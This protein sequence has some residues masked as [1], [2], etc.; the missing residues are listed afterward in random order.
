MNEAI[1]SRRRLAPVNQALTY[2]GCGRT[3]AY[4]LIGDGEIVAVKM[5]SRTMIDLDSV[6]AYH[7]ALPRVTSKGS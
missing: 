3:L 7:A 6:D 4:K 5:G 2:I 1:K